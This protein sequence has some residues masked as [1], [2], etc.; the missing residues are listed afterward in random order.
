METNVKKRIDSFWGLHLDY[1]ATP[2]DGLQGE[3]L[4]EENVRAICQSLKPDFIQIDCKGH[5]GWASYPS[6]VGNAMPEFA[7]DTLAL[8]RKVTR[9]EGVALYMHYSGVYDRKYC[10]EHPEENSMWADGTYTEGATCLGGK[11]VEDLMIP[12]LLE[13][14]G[15]Y[16]VDGVWVDGDCW[17]AHPDFRPDSLAA[18]E[19]ETGIDLAGQI[20]SD[21]SH[22][23]FE[24]YREFHR[25]LFR[26]YVR[27][28]VDAVHAQYPEFQIASNWAFSDHMPE[29]VT[30]NVDFLSGDLNPTNSFHSARYAARALAQQ[31]MP[32]D[33]MA[34]NF[35]QGI[36]IRSGYA[37]KHPIQI[38]QEAA[39][40]IST[41]GAFQDYV[42]QLRDG[43]PN[44]VEL[45]NLAEVSAF[46]RARK[47]WCFRG[48]PIHQA[49]LLLST[50]DRHR[51]SWTLYQRT[52]YER[53]MGATALLC[54]IGQSLEIICEHTLAA[55]RDEYKMI[56]IPELYAGLADETVDRLLDYVK[57]GGSLLLIGKKTCS[58]F[59]S[60]PDVPFTVKDRAEFVATA[61]QA[62]QDGHNNRTSRDYQPYVFTLDHARYG[63]A[64]SPCE[65]V[66]ADGVTEAYVGERNRQTAPVAVTVSYGAGQICAI[67]FDVGAQ[68]LSGAQYL[69]RTLLRQVTDRLYTPL[70]R[71]ESACGRLELM[72]LKKDGRLMLQLVN[73]GGTHADSAS[74]TDDCIPPVLDIKLSLTLSKPPKKLILQPEGRELPFTCEEDKIIVTVDRLNI[75]STLVVEE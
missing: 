17:M 56:V 33:L 34:W 55:H 9:E 37:P 4:T 73:A 43:S 21:R 14:A 20:P 45:N 3:T 67:G 5:P 10:S 11:Y 24:A 38:M 51:E 62:T 32:W 57:N 12:Q 42:P 72:A 2:K 1:H 46:V 44:M 75:H 69:H 65:I 22:P 39:A 66:A 70:A 31:E 35:R 26:R 40:V 6:K 59:A 23:Q 60:R 53:A 29:P 27:Y 41:G 8:W 13:L 15:D 71:V 47:D 61:E 58:L 30:A 68:Y 18:F 74:A 16:G 50:Y 63:A 52:G 54:D 19:R 36:G 48:T 25:E 64:F 28:Y 7:K 49:A